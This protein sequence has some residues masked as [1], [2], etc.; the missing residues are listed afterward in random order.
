MFRHLTKAFNRFQGKFT[1]R[2]RFILFALI[3]FV[4]I[5]FPT[6]WLLETQNFLLQRNKTKIEGNQLQQVL[7]SLLNKI[8]RHEIIEI[9]QIQLK[10]KQ[11]ESLERL[12]D[13][14]YQELKRLEQLSLDMPPPYAQSPFRTGFSTALPQKIAVN[15]ILTKWATF[16]KAHHK[17]EHEII[18]A[19]DAM[20]KQLQRELQK[21]GYS[22]ELLLNPQLILQE[23]T[24]LSL[25]V[26]PEAQVILSKIFIKREIAD[27]ASLLLNVGLIK[28]NIV[29]MN[30][31]FLAALQTLEPTISPVQYNLFKDSLKNYNHALHE[32]IQ[33]LEQEKTSRASPAFTT[34]NLSNLIL[35]ALNANEQTRQLLIEISQEILNTQK[36]K[37]FL[38]KF[39]TILLVTLSSFIIIFAILFRILTG[40]ILSLLSLIQELSKGN[41][42]VRTDFKN[43]DEFGQIGRA[44]V[45]ISKKMK[46]FIDK[47]NALC[48]LVQDS[49]FEIDHTVKQQ[50]VSL[51]HQEEGTQRIETIARQIAGNA[52]SIVN[53]MTEFTALSAQFDLAGNVRSSLSQAQSEMSELARVPVDIVNQLQNVDEKVTR[54]KDL[55]GFMIHLSDQTHLLSL[56]A[57]IESNPKIKI[58]KEITKNIELFAAKSLTSTNE[59][60]DIISDASQNVVLS[61]QNVDIYLKGIYESGNRL[62]LVSQQL[63]H[64]TEQV[65]SQTA[66]FLNVTK[67]MEEQAKDAEQIMQSIID[68]NATSKKNSFAIQEL[69]KTISTL[70]ESAASLEPLVKNFTP[71][72]PV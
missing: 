24:F 48:H 19:H 13:E 50:A 34:L 2:Q 49:S 10:I 23:L 9:A 56:N 3:F 68:M 61:V 7:G 6:Y 4:V 42:S 30:A 64:I 44:L 18:E 52:R 59:I 54:V 62:S 12:E 60:Q 51:I 15:M 53:K 72:N 69:S 47:L 55:I 31:L 71:S 16:L 22:Y 37:F 8:L 38:Q 45:L 20:I 40:H 1:Y 43:N 14:I 29:N 21:L 41:F 26:F 35:E 65:S 39:L 46:T 5:P 66:Q 63:T 70:K 27:Q 36:W 28:S 58:F 11:T 57:A 25:S 67:V 32:A 33:F 17:N